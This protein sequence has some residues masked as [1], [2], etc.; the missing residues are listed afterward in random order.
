MS[1]AMV[2]LG[3]AAAVLGMISLVPIVDAQTT[4]P[5]APQTGTPPAASQSGTTSGPASGS[6]TTMGTTGTTTGTQHQLD[7]VRSQSE[8][9]KREMNQGGQPGANQGSGSTGTGQPG[10]TGTQSGT[11]PSQ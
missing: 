3:T 9:I 10:G 1:K 4:S 2:T 5:T 11:P 6:P 7:S 8:S